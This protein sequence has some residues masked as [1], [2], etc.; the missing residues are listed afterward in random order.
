M[1]GC[2]ANHT[3]IR[4]HNINAQGHGKLFSFKVPLPGM[5]CAI[6]IWSLLEFK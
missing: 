2:P 5:K 4:E 6:E 3:S 1:K